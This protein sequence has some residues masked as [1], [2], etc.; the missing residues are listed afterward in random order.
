MRHQ[1]ELGEAFKRLHLDS[2]AFVIPNAWDIGTARLMAHVGFKAVATTSA[3]FA[4][5]R[6]MPDGT[7]DREQMLVHLSEVAS[8]IDL[9][10]SAD[11]ENGYGDNPDT[12]AETV[13][14]AAAAG[15]VSGSIEDVTKRPHDPIY[16]FDLAVERIAAAADAAR[17]LPFPFT[18]TARADNYLVGRTDLGDTIRRLQA[19]QDAGADVLYAPGLRNIDDIATVIRSVDRPVNVLMGLAGVVYTVSE[20]AAVG[21]KRISVGGALTRRALGAVLASLTEI[22]T[23]G[24]FTFTKDAISS[25]DM[26]RIFALPADKD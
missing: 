25:A 10:V 22:N 13:R 23:S 15:V 16:G 9:P 4:F 8:G 19:Y 21:V 17:Q 18:L 26:N 6:G 2:G 7:I 11:L 12:V 1:T 20:L 24:T 14:L 5:S 3:G